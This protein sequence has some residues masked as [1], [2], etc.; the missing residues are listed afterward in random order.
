MT[1]RYQ[2]LPWVRQGAAG[3]FKNTDNLSPVLARSDG[4]PL[5]LL[6]V[7][8]KINTATPVEVPLRIFGPGDLTGIDPRVVIRTDPPARSADFEPNFMPCI[9][10]DPP[11]FPWLFTP[12]S[13]GADGKLRP[14][15]VLAVVEASEETRL[16][17]APDLPLPVLTAPPGELPDLVESYAWAHAQVIQSDPSQAVDGIFSGLPDQNLSRLVCPRR[18]KP[19]TRYLACLV[20]AFDAGRKAGLGEEVS[21]EDTASLRPAWEASQSQVRLP[22]YYHWEFS[23]GIGGDFESLASRLQGRQAPAGIGRRPLR[24]ENQ[25]FGLPDQGVLTLEGALTSTEPA[26][27]PAP[28]DD[29]MNRLRDLLNLSGDQPV[30]TPPIYSRWQASQSVVPGAAGGLAWLRQ[31]NLDPSARVPAGLGVR[32]VQERQDQ[33]VAAAWE[34]LGDAQGVAQVERRL[35]VAVALLDSF[36][37]RRV[38]AMETGQLV[39]FLGPAQT[40]IRASP[41]T[42][43]A[44][45][46]SQGL[47]GSFSSASFRRTLRPAG[48]LSRKGGFTSPVNLQT[49]AARL[50]AAVP[51]IDPAPGAPGWVTAKL[52]RGIL[53][54]TQVTPAQQRYREAIGDVQTYFDRFTGRAIPAPRPAFTFTAAFKTNLVGNLDPRQAATPRFFSRLASPAGEVQPPARPGESVIAGPSF[55]QP[56]YLALAELSPEFLLPGVGQIDVDTVTLLNSNPRF[57]EAF[58]LGLNHELASELLWREFPTDLR[59]TYFRTF[60]DARGAQPP[61]E[62]LPPIHTWDPAKNLGEQFSSGG[63]QLV[64]LIR[65]ELLQRYPDALFYAVRAQTLNS[66]GTEEKFPQF[67]GRLE[68][69]ITFL[70]FDLTADQAR[71]G[72]NDPGWFFAIQ[73]QPSAPRFGLDESRTKEHV[74]TWNDLAWS[75]VN[76]PPGEHLKLIGLSVPPPPGPVWGF[77]SAHMAAILRQRPVRVA[78]HARVLLPPVP[79]PEPPP[80]TPPAPSTPPAPPVRPV[81]PIPPVIV[82]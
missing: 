62:Q 31:L 40:R 56:M 19:A 1:A 25:P 55:P 69:D 2:F 50:G 18:L 34:Q 44:S 8:L 58:M 23:T 45:L 54:P 63:A 29:F 61:F 39:Q 82:R 12:A 30:V 49:A 60:W 79:E 21:P 3:A 35:E 48:T 38:Q 9:E 72:A 59:Q 81:P 4:A 28:S 16:V 33:L 57:I 52:V 73:E 22:V 47:P 66:L 5:S 14:W 17:S 7:R 77:N 51:A 76:T 75:D 32:I 68:P 53:F 6:G 67:R 64:L 71:G 46:A 11:D 80:P 10:F 78:I 42:L 24:V 37:R 43:R 20:P 13:A 41:Q 36:V 26:P 70:G 15:L 65:G 74:D 27:L